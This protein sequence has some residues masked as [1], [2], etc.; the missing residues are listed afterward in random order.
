MAWK[1]LRAPNLAVSAP[2]GYCLNYARTAF[3]APGGTAYASQA[4]TKTKFKHLDQSFPPYPVPIWFSYYVNGENEG[5]VAIHVPGKG[6]YSSPYRK[7]TGHAV[8][9]SIPELIR[10]YSGNGRHPMA[11]QGWSEDINGVRVVEPAAS[12]SPAPSIAVEI[13]RPDFVYSGAG[14]ASPKLKGGVKTGQKYGPAA[15]M[16]NGW[17]QITFTGKIGYIQPGSYKRI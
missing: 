4:W 5:H 15:I 13:T 11:Y 16:T 9:S 7:G 8:L 3:G 14:K 10:I 2:V 6:I 1:Q 12:P 17:A